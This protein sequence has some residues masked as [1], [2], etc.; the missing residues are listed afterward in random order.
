MSTEIYESYNKEL[1][2]IF[3]E[4]ETTELSHLTI[5]QAIVWCHSQCEG[6]E[7]CDK[8]LQ[9]NA[10]KE[11]SKLTLEKLKEEFDWW[12]GMLVYK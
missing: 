7:F 10:E 2:E 4:F 3:P 8:E 9:M 11:Y 12:Y 5:G 1:S 6:L